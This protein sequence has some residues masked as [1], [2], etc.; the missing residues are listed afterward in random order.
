MQHQAVRVRVLSRGG[1]QLAAGGAGRG[2]AGKG[3]CAVDGWA[4]GGEHQ[5]DY[6]RPAEARVWAGLAKFQS[7]IWLV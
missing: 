5:G 3:G 6:K 4:C 1:L 7:M 2:R